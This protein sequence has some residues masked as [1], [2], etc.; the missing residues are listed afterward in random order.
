MNLDKKYVVVILLMLLIYTSIAFAG[1]KKLTVYYNAQ[2][3][4]SLKMKV[5]VPAYFDPS[6]SGYWDRLT[7]QAAKMPGCLY[8]IANPDNG[9]GSSY[10]ATYNAAINKMH[11]NG[12]R[13]IGY[14]YT[15]YGA[16]PLSTA[17]SDIDK[18][19]SYYPTM[20]G[21]FLDC[22]DNVA[23]KENYYSQ[24]YAYIKQ[25]DSSSLVV[26]NPGTNTIENYLVYSGKRVS[27]V[28]CIFET[29]P[30]F[31]SWTPAP[32]C[33]KYS[34]DNFYV[35][36]YN[37]SSTQYFNTVNRAASLNIGWI[38]CTSD[39]L[40]NPY[41][42][43]PPY[44]ENLCNYIITGIFTPDTVI[45]QGLIK[46]DGSFNDWQNV[47][48]LNT[49][50][51]P[52]AGAGDSPNA[53][54]DYIN[55]W[56]ANDSTNLFLSYQVGGSLSASYFY[57]VFIDI[58]GN[59]NTGYVYKDSASI[60]AEFMVEN[61]NLWKYTG[62]GGSNW[63]WS[64]VPGFNKSNNGGRTEMS[65]PVKSLFP[66]AANSEIRLIFQSNSSTAPYDMME[67]DPADYTNQFYLYKLKKFTGIENKSSGS[68]Q[69][70]FNLNQNYPNPFNPGTLISYQIPN[71]G[72]VILKIYNVMGQEVETLVNKFQSAGNY[73]I[74]FNSAS[75]G[76]LSSGIYFYHLQVGKYSDTKKMI[77]IK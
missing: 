62:T 74:S 41:D 22:Q 25:K 3:G 55:F 4:D 57:H 77:L 43:L 15:N 63:S 30:G 46:I 68:K 66:A 27:D 72:R 28:V 56:A 42:T 8:A 32:W 13:V 12:G 2:S 38:F 52:S 24:L 10:D 1:D 53:D 11:A 67:I 54:A 19:Y 60:G 7:L 73:T 18:W 75:K 6:G 50:P 44:F 33:S 20:D 17:K 70:T 45:S 21:V 49:P 40:P 35:I 14:V 39:N 36:P 26:A 51:N 48:K 69:L 23:G 76:I 9:P 65:I 71:S 37:I 34:R 16:I 64:Q 29:S 47:T 5:L 59:K 61:D 58:D 31:D